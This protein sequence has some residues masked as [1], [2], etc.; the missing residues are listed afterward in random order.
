MLSDD[1]K[2]SFLYSWG[3]GIE[4]CT[5]TSGIRVTLQALAVES[6]GSGRWRARWG[7]RRFAVVRA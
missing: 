6:Q 5:W 4:K 2:S 3:R 1:C 7:R